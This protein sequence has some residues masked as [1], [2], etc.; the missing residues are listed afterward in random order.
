MSKLVR[1]IKSNRGEGY[2]DVVISVLVLMMVMVLA[3][4]VFSFLTVKQDM[5]YFAKE[6]IYCAA[7]YGRTT[8]EVDS[9][10]AELTAETGLS[11]TVSWQTSY[12]NASAKTVQYD[13]T[14]TVTLTYN[15]Y[16][17]GFGVFKIPI[18]LTAKYT[19][20]SMKYWK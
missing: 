7:T 4:N 14:I 17:K 13:D 10:K 1:V 2:I 16:L 3:L 12:F 20:L 6:M 8:D 15:T 11:P 18:T 5:D 9:R 19:G